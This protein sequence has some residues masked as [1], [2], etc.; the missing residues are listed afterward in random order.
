MA[1]KRKETKEKEPKKA[2]QELQVAKAQPA[3]PRRGAVLEHF[4]ELDRMFDRMAENFFRRGWLRPGGVE[5]PEFPSLAGAE[6]RVPKVDVVD[7]DKEVVVHAELPGVKK[8]DLEVTLGEDTVTIRGRSSRE[9]KEERENFYRCE[10]HRGEF[11]RTLRL[12]AAVDGDKAKARFTDGV[13]ELTLPK[14]AQAQRRSV[15]I[16]AD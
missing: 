2:E 10:I 13:L 6:E 14:L 3:A 12:P 15:K 8:E 7:R 16:D 11:A 1:D 5:W 4:D 9:E